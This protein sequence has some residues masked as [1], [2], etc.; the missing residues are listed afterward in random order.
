MT[1]LPRGASLLRA[2]PCALLACLAASSARAGG[3]AVLDVP[4]RKV[5]PEEA[6]AMTAP[7]RGRHHRRQAI[8]CRASGHGRDEHGDALFDVVPGIGAVVDELGG[9]A[10]AVPVDLVGEPVQPGDVA[11]VAG[12]R[13]AGRVGTGR[14]GHAHRS[15][16]HHCRAA[17]CTRAVVGQLAVA[18]ASVRLGDG[19]AHRGH[20]HPVPQGHGPDPTGREQLVEG[21]GWPTYWVATRANSCHHAAGRDGGRAL[22]WTGRC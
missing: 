15:D 5:T 20:E 2:I 4:P 3:V 18:D 10:S 16:D 1:S 11:V 17:P 7:Y 12:R 21:H 8:G 22:R 19:V 9:D 6:A 13:L 14:V